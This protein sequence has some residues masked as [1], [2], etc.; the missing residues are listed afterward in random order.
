MISRHKSR[1]SYPRYAELVCFVIEPQPF[2]G[3]LGNVLGNGWTPKGDP[4]F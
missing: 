4:G 2:G 1:Q 3:K